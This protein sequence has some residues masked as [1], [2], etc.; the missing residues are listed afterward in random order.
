MTIFFNGLLNRGD[1]Q[2]IT[3]SDMITDN[4]IMCLIMNSMAYQTYSNY[5][6]EVGC[7]PPG[8]SILQSTIHVSKYLQLHHFEMRRLFILYMYMNFPTLY[9]RY[10]IQNPKRRTGLII[11]HHFTL[12]TSI[13]QHEHAIRILR[14]CVICS[15]PQCE[16]G[17]EIDECGSVSMYERG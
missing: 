12:K 4:L 11:V 7:S 13:C 15:N 10:L 5:E 16:R 1:R 8:I 3:R 17:P 2:Y 9:I 6:S 14:V